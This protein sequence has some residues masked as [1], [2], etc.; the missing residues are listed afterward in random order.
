M[1]HTDPRVKISLRLKIPNS[2]IANALRSGEGLQL[3][4]YIIVQLAIVYLQDL[5]NFYQK[6]LEILRRAII[7]KN[8]LTLLAV[9]NIWQISRPDC[10]IYW[11]LGR[12]IG[13][14]NIMKPEPTIQFI[15]KILWLS[16]L[17]SPLSAGHLK[18]L[19]GGSQ[20]TIFSGYFSN[21]MTQNI[22]R[23]LRAWEVS[24]FGSLAWESQRVIHITPHKIDHP[25]KLTEAEIYFCLHLKVVLLQLL[26]YK[27]MSIWEYT[28]A[29]IQ[30]MGVQFLCTEL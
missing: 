19:T 13:G 6:G 7:L 12:D 14:Q 2:P 5:Y 25:I 15:S 21:F 30:D 8:Q 26:S 16:A 3:I 11:P 9:K 22:S 18:L 27:C 29:G 28:W 1:I 17:Q 23:S 4:P 20:V 10:M 24:C